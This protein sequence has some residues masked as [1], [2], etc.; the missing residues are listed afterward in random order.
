[1]RNLVELSYLD[2]EEDE[3]YNKTINN[4]FEVCFKEENLYEVLQR[5]A[6]VEEKKFFVN[7]QVST[8]REYQNSGKNIPNLLDFSNSKLISE[9]VSISLDINNRYSFLYKGTNT[10]MQEF[11][12]EFEKIYSLMEQNF[13]KWER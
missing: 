5:V 8:F 9:G 10:K 2:I 6:L 1:M 12:V 3:K 4:V 13:K 7:Q 11:D